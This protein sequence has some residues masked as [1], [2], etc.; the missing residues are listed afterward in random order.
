MSISTADTS[1][2]VYIL[3]AFYIHKHPLYLTKW[4]QSVSEVLRELLY[5]PNLYDFT[6]SFNK[7]IELQN[8]NRETVIMW[9]ACGLPAVG[10]CC[11]KNIWNSSA[12]VNSVLTYAA[13][14]QKQTLHEEIKK[15]CGHFHIFFA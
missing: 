6:R 12:G 11:V 15:P 1:T 3:H 4:E 13:N 10:W 9:R 2:Y 8:I 5:L 14:D 7:F